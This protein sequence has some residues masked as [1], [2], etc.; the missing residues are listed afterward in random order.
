VV[1]WQLV[2]D[3]IKDAADMGMPAAR[4]MLK[5]GGLWIKGVSDPVLA[6]LQPIL[7]AAGIDQRG[8]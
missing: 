8:A 2:A 4:A 5:A 6:K 1:C 7:V 3:V